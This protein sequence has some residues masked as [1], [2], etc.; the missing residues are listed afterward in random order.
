MFWLFDESTDCDYVFVYD[1]SDRS[2]EYIN[3]VNLVRSGVDYCRLMKFSDSINIAKFRLL[4]FELHGAEFI[5]NYCNYRVGS[6]YVQMRLNI[7]K[8]GNYCTLEVYFRHSDMIRWYY[9]ICSPDAEKYLSKSA[10]NMFSAA[11]KACRITIEIPTKML[12][13][14]VSLRSQNNF[15]GVM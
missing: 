7:L 4:G 12:E 14:L 13:Y 15:D 9:I 8:A 6:L 1:D 3:Y 10:L 2:V 11:R 5:L